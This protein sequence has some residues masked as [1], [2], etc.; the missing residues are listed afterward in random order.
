MVGNI[1]HQLNKNISIFCLKVVVIVVVVVAVAEIAVLV[2]GD[3]G[4][5]GSNDVS[6][7]CGGVSDN[8][9]ACDCCWDCG[10]GS[11][12]DKSGHHQQAEN[13]C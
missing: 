3:S 5:V 9:G 1:L 10:S 6:N 8:G 4:S 11:V 2:D 12:L 13:R 7:A